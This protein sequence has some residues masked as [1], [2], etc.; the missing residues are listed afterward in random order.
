[1]GKGLSADSL[2]KA[3]SLGAPEYNSGL[4]TKDAADTTSPNRVQIGPKAEPPEGVD[5]S[6]IVSI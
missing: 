5:P 3:N 1:M 6:L 4:P 2:H